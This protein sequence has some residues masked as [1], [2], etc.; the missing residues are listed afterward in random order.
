MSNLEVH[1]KLFRS[2]AGDDAKENLITLCS[3]CHAQC[4][5]MDIKAHVNI[6]RVELIS[7]YPRMHASES[8]QQKPDFFLFG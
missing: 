5:A 2:H 6:A 7:A 4:H 1:H 8:Q 3:A